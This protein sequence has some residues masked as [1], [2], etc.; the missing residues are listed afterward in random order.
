MKIIDVIFLYRS[1]LYELNVNLSLKMSK[2]S[3]Y[4]YDYMNDLL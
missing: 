3:S 1:G 2:L 4:R